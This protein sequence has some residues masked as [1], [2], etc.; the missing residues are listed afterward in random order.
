M[1]VGFAPKA[2][3]RQKAIYS[4]SNLF[5]IGFHVFALLRFVSFHLKRNSLHGGN[6]P[7]RFEIEI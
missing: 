5:F 4:I 2:P 1:C 6:E 7:G 3:V